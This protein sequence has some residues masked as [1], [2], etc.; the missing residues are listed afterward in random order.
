MKYPVYAKSLL[1]ESLG[2]LLPDEIVHR[3]KQGFTFPWNHWLRNELRSFCNTHITMLAEREFINGPALLKMWTDFLQGSKRMKWMD[4]W[5]FV[6]LNY[7]ME[8]NR[9][10]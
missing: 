3:K 10:N 5:L 1:V 7:W 4:I 2:T 9:L 8:R 6:V